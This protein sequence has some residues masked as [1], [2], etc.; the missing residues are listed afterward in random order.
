M[1]LF[2]QMLKDENYKKLF[3]RLPDD[4]KAV[5]MASIRQFVEQFE[6]AVLQPIEKLK[7]E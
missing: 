6:K 3:D 4:E 7:T 1:S 5:I 2:D